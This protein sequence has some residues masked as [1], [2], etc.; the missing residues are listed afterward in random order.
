M[1]NGEVEDARTD[2]VEDQGDIGIVKDAAIA[3]PADDLDT[4]MPI[5]TFQMAG[6]RDGE[7]LAF[8]ILRDEVDKTWAF[9]FNDQQLPTWLC[10]VI[11]GLILGFKDPV[12]IRM[13]VFWARSTQLINSNYL[14]N[15]ALVSEIMDYMR[16][17]FTV[18]DA[19]A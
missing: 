6:N 10:D 16:S 13:L 5:K 18:E 3:G 4:F 8:V 9:E 17:E 15:H 19:V 7:I 1:M 12:W 14:G 2:V 11:G